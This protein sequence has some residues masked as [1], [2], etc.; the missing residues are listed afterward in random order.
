MQVAGPRCFAPPLT[1][2]M[3]DRYRRLVGK[4][5]PKTEIRKVLD[6]LLACCEAWWQAPEPRARR[7]KFGVKHAVVP[8]DEA[9]KAALRGNLPTRDDLATCSTVLDGIDAVTEKEL[10]DASF[11]L[12]WHCVELSRGREPMTKDDQ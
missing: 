2:E 12:L 4:V 6:S 5:R 1:E 8:L 7:T 10:R 9:G 3:L 11:H